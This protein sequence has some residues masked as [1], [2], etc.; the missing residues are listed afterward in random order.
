MVFTSVYPFCFRFLELYV[1]DREGPSGEAPAIRSNDDHGRTP[2][3]LRRRFM[4]EEARTEHAHGVRVLLPERG[5]GHPLLKQGYR[6]LS[7]WPIPNSR[8]WSESPLRP[9]PCA[10]AVVQREVIITRSLLPKVASCGRRLPIA[11]MPAARQGGGVYADYTKTF[12]YMHIC[13]CVRKI[14]SLDFVEITR[15][16]CASRML[17]RIE[18]DTHVALVL[19]CILV[20][21]LVRTS[22]IRSPR[23]STRRNNAISTSRW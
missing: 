4:L 22:T 7:N 21:V 6:N 17:Y 13:I 23:P 10:P 9:V 12:I 20:F 2:P 19:I 11:S 1:D 3:L 14:S 15:A 16:S 18:G 5:F 8:R